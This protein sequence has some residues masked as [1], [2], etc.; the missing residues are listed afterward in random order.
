ML[1][2]VA[3]DLAYSMYFSR[4]SPPSIANLVLLEWLHTSIELKFELAYN[5]TCIQGK[6]LKVISFVP[7]VD[8]CHITDD[9]GTKRVAGESRKIE[10]LARE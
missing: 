3:D 10:E 9:K 6:W 7:T 4:L 5:W 8:T 1:N 2:S